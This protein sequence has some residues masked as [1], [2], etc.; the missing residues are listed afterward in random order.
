M[1][2][3]YVARDPGAV[4]VLPRVRWRLGREVGLAVGAGVVRRGGG[5]EGRGEVTM[6]LR[7]AAGAGSK[8][9]WYLAGGV[10]G[11][12]GPSGGGFLM[13]GAGVELPAGQGGGW[14]GEVGVAGGVRLAAGY[15]VAVGRRKRRKAVPRGRPSVR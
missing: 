12:T 14:W 1:A 8:P 10:A 7:F 11:V 3:V 15:Q 4:G 6:Q 13:A 2:V 5:W 9:V